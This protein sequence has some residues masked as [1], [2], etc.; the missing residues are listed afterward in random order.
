MQCPSCEAEVTSAPATCD[1][2]HSFE[3]GTQAVTVDDMEK[4]LQGWGFGLLAIGAIS[5]FTSFLDPVWGGIL[6]AI[7]ILTLLVQR[8]GMFIVIGIGLLL[9]G[10]MNIT[11]SL[12]SINA[13]E[14]GCFDI[15]WIVF[16]VLQLLWGVNELL[17]FGRYADLPGTPA[18]L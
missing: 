17:K 1:C 2:S 7:D 12:I 15:F 9:A 13:G 11:S 4:D 3:T 8:R 16:G 14:G 6:I 10:V 5:I 18:A